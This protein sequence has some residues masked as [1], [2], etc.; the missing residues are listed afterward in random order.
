[1]SY[2]DFDKTKLI[3][4]EYSLSKELIR[5]NRAGSYASTTIVGCNTRKYH[6]LL[7]SPL[8]QLDGESHVLLSSLEETVIQ[9]N[10]EFRLG[11]HKYPGNIYEPHGHR[12]IREF[13]RDPIPST[14]YRV[15]GV[16]LKKEIVLT[17]KDERVLIRYTLLDAHSPTKIRLNPFLAFRNVHTLSKS[18]M[19]VQK[20]CFDAKNGIKTK[21]YDGYPFLFMQI[22]K[23]NEFV[24][25]PHWYNDIEYFEEQKRGY[26]YQEDLYVPGFFEFDIK[27]G[28]S[29]I[30]SGGLS[31]IPTHT[32]KQR[33]NKELV[34]RIPRDSFENN[35]KNSAQQFFIKKGNDT[36]II[37]GFPWFGS[38]A[39]DTFISLPGLTLSVGDF[40]TCKSVLDTMTKK[41]KG[42]LFINTG[43]DNQDNYNSVDAPLWYFWAIQN[44]YQEIGAAD[45]IWKSYGKA[46]KEILSG[47]K[48]GIDFN[49]KMH[50]NSLIYSGE[51]GNALTWMDAI[52][53]GKPVTPRIG[54]GV[55]INAL[56]YNAVMF[57]LEIAKE[58]NDQA[59]VDE[60]TDLPAKI[61][62]SFVSTF[63]DSNRNY[64]ADFVHG[65]NKNWDV[66]PN[67]IFAA[68]LKYSPIDDEM[69][70]AVLTVVEKE[71]LT[72]KGLRTL[73]PK[74]LS[75]KGRCKGDLMTRDLAYHQGSVWPWL[76]GHFAEAYLNLHGKSGVKLIDRYLAG[77]EDEM[78]NHG[79]GSIS[80]IFDGDPPH[81][82]R[83]TISQAWSVAEILRSKQ[84]V[85]N[86]E[87]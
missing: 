52:V 30:F 18:N 68:S 71:L 39:R 69:K 84:L 10:K 15:G 25:V 3:N 50:D 22:S 6:G 65:E 5:S 55:E 64:L 72:V 40:K 36:E 8:E 2:I 81:K 53:N 56:W 38:W 9:H 20:K 66:R 1:M 80:E 37:A 51:T 27:K 77:F 61:K 35:L 16:V 19:Y 73:S 11:I 79:V 28:E 32:L 21:L 60:W 85:R 42:S 78:S 47:Y 33:F 45:K 87:L 62:N 70:N 82:A 57:A 14:T 29:V 12:Y 67:Q 46:M 31:E 24:K 43:S 44:Y 54:Y 4:L 48:K 75:Y 83:G 41:L 76:F 58:V 17:Q 86:I 63:W 7:V 26:D 34:N 59:F 23:K 74:N 13:E 49:I